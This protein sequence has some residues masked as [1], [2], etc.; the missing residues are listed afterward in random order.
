MKDPSPDRLMETIRA[1]VRRFSLV[2]RADLSCCG[3]TVAQ[4]ATLE[5]LAHENDL[6]LGT[7]AR[8]LGIDKSTLTRNVGRLKDLGLVHTI[9]DP[10]DRRATMA[11]LTNDGHTAAQR[12]ARIES[13]FARSV[14]D[15]LGPNGAAETLQILDRLL[16]AVRSASQGCC[17]G[18]F[19]HLTPHAPPERSSHD[20]G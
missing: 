17:P 6:R 12:I 11:R 16:A 9:P 5:A 1:L 18:A 4:A 7:L 8:R 13:D 20:H 14:N 15:A 10:S 2:E 19:D 3:M